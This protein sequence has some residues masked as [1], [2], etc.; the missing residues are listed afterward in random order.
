VS[1]KKKLLLVAA[2]MLVVGIFLMVLPSPG[3]PALECVPEG[4][5]SSGFRDADQDNCPVSIESYN[6]YAE[7]SSS[8]KWDNI[9]GLVLV[10]GGLGVGVTALVRGRSKRTKPPA[11]A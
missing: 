6:D 7:W 5:P 2:V 4:Q 10:L 11:Q 9:G 8:P 1:T 3:E